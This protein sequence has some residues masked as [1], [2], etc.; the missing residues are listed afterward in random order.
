M[1]I[2]QFNDCE[3]QLTD[4]YY[5]INSS[6]HFSIWYGAGQTVSV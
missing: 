5:H 3:I 6:F 2:V 1:G 4:N